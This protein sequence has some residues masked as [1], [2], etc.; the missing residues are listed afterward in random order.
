MN[1][2]LIITATSHFTVKVS[3]KIVIILLDL[4]GGVE[5]S[6]MVIHDCQLIGGKVTEFGE[7]TMV[8][9]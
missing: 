7:I 5:V 9:K 1:S 3:I 4:N 8:M 6:E 2:Y